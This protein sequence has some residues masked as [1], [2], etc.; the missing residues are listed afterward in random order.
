MWYDCVC[1]DLHLY[2]I[3]LCIYNN[4]DKSSFDEKGSNRNFRRDG[5]K[6][7]NDTNTLI[8]VSTSDKSMRKLAQKIE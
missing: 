8:T 5:R 2:N 1:V 6:I 3:G 4:I 7:K